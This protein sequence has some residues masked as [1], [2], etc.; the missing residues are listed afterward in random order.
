MANRTLFKTQ[1]P[2]Q[3]RA[4]VNPK[5]LP[6]VKNE[7]GGQAFSFEDKHALAQ[8]AVTGAFG[9][10]FYVD[11]STQLDRAKALVAKVD[12]PFIAKL[13]V[14]AHE[15]GRMKDM[16]A[17]LAAVLHGR[18]ESELLAQVFPRVIS[19]F[20]MLSNFVQIVRSGAVGRKS[21]GSAT[22]TLIKNW[23][24]GKTAQ[25]VFNG[26]IGL[27]SPS[28]ADIIKMVHPRANGFDQDAV[29]AY[30]TEA[31]GW[32]E[33]TGNLPEDV[34]VFEALK[35][36]Q[37]NVVPNVPFRAL[38]NVELSAAQWREIALNM[39]WDTLRQNLNM[40][41]RR[42]V[43][44]DKGFLHTVA[45]KLASPENVRKAKVMPYQLYT[46]FQNTTDLPSELTNALQD[47]AEVSTENVP[48]FNRDVALLVD[49]S[50]SMGGLIMG[51]RPGVPAGKTRCVDVAGLMASCV[52]R[53]N[54]NGRVILF[55]H[56]GGY[57]GKVN[58]VAEMHLNARDSI[59]TNAKNIADALGGGTDISLPF[60]AL[61]R[62][63][64][65]ADLLIMV[66]DNESWSG[67]GGRL[68][69][70]AEWVSYN[71][72]VKNSKL[73]NI[74]IQPNISTQVPDNKNVLNIGGFNDSIWLTIEQFVN[75][76]DGADFV[77]TI[78]S[79]KL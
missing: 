11:A 36:G 20:K 65:K 17:F 28:V 32:E 30:L 57:G 8:L 46:T 47:A 70:N 14:Y 1:T 49:V 73:V 2:L 79:V 52:L 5:Q 21:F 61:N 69:A 29:F 75:R 40:L 31:R 33:K 10:T 66:S 42:K 34:R 45:E 23:I 54:K 26:S 41:E 53:Q 24:A 38:T 68:G 50:G 71:N 48:S 7:A 62:E 58:G 74:D 16:P 4:S 43:F 15:S 59:M 78:E 27:S 22:K 39:P 35:R 9:N 44:E 60:M 55:N 77:Q 63:K 12:A 56:L 3:S 76:K 37:T 6:V 72:R 51:T 18:G 67:Y 25:Q 13:A 64:A 19:T